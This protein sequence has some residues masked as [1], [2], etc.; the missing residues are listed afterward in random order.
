MDEPTCSEC[1][2]VDNLRRGMCGTCYASWRLS[3]VSAGLPLPPKPVRKLPPRPCKV[4]KKDSDGLS[5]GM[6][7]N[8]YKR[9]SRGVDPA[10]PDRRRRPAEVRF[11]EKVDKNG[12]IPAHRPD[13]GPCWVW[14]GAKGPL[15][16]GRMGIDG[17][18][19][20]VHRF[21]YEHLVGPIPEGLDVD[22]VCRNPS[23]VNAPGGHLEPV[24]HRENVRRGTAPAAANAVKTH[25]KRGHEFTPE[26]T[27]I[28]IG[29][30]GKQMRNCRTCERERRPPVVRT[31]PLKGSKT[32][33][34]NGHEY[35][36]E[37]TYIIPSSGSKTCRTCVRERRA[38]K[39]A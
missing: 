30:K 24:T 28:Q 31:V 3:Y 21:A 34:K 33:C 18:T 25:C 38:R 1:S 36:P 39:A 22:H 6:C 20:Q 23:C 9:W 10:S 2:R 37:N 14:T 17:K 16:Y 13:L 26:N 35:T 15:G 5:R 7:G 4:C 8:C 27:R 32:H 12:P 19:V 29:H 11:L